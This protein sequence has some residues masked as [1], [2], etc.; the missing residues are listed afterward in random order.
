MPEH[1]NE[2]KNLSRQ[3][4]I[5]IFVRFSRPWFL[6][7]ADKFKIAVRIKVSVRRMPLEFAS[8]YPRQKP[9]GECFKNLALLDEIPA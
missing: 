6:K 4:V 9:F 3:S 5:S 7:S 1:L 2:R 8:S